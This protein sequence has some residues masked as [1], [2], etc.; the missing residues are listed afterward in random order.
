[1][2]NDKKQPEKAP[3]EVSHEEIDELRREMRSAQITAWAEANQQKIIAGVVAIIVLIAGISMWKDHRESQRASAATLYHQALGAQ[4][5]E[6]RLS[7]LQAII[8]DY[9]NTVYGGLARLLLANADPE[10]AASY[11]QTLM[12]RSDVDNG[13][14]TQ[15]RLDL[16]RIRI[17]AGDKAAAAKLL[18]A[19]APADYEQLRQYLMAQATADKTGRIEHLKKARDATSHDAELSQRIEEQLSTLGAG[20]AGQD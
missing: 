16:A 18:E 13:I 2:S 3:I 10:N 17:K 8:K 11:L 15:A 14:R 19:P 7:M 6:D 9:D 20:T 5:L 12:G 4:H 1:M